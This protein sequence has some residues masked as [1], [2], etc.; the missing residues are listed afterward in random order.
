MQ[1]QVTKAELQR[2]ERIEKNAVVSIDAVPEIEHREA[3]KQVPEVEVQFVE[4]DVNMR[5][6]RSKAR[7]EDLSQP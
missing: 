5:R 4:K 6:R 3:I 7:C 2:V 1:K